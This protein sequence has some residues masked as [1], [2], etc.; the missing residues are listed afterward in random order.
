MPTYF[1]DVARERELEGTETSTESFDRMAFAARA[2]ALVKPANMRVAIA[3]G[4]S[5][6]VVESG[7]LW[8]RPEGARWA[9][10][11][12]PPRA[13]HRAIAAAVAA[14]AGPAPE[15]YVLDTLLASA[16]E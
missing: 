11:C 8:G 3:A 4:R 15:P 12:V 10:L 9:M 2:V 6:V 7:R 14:L 5:R 1:S 13:S 16:A